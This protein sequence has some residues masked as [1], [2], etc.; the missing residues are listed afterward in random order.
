MRIQAITR[1]NGYGLTKDVQVLREALDGHA[2]DFTD[3]SRPRNSGRWD[4]NV[5]LELSN[6][7]HFRT[8]TINAL[9]P[10]PEWFD[11]R[12]MPHLSGY[13]I[14]LA[15]TRDCERIFKELHPKVVYIGWTSPDPGMTVDYEMRGAVHCRGN[16]SSKGTVELMRAAGGAGLPITILTKVRLRE[17]APKG[18][19]VKVGHMPDA[20]YAEHR[21]TPIH[22]CPS[23]YEGFGHYINEARAMGAVIVTTDAAPMDELVTTDF[24][25]LVPACGTRQAHTATESIVCVD[26]LHDALRAC[27]QLDTD[28]K[29]TLGA[30]ARQ[31]Y[32]R[33]RETFTNT[34]RSLIQ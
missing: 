25:I 15:K 22:L 30:M 17:T 21:R 23:S 34:I 13:D 14:I 32:E 29:R 31:A 4:W 16:S 24:G 18:V 20:A 6:P 12:W 5:H 2:M 3:W 33:D 28:T 19:T 8:G 11:M 9:V 7:A 26:S 1:N 27:S 10:N